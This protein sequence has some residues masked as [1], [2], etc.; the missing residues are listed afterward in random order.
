ML[1]GLRIKLGKLPWR[2][3]RALGNL[4]YSLHL[5]S[6][7]STHRIRPST[8]LTIIIALA[9][10]GFILAGGIYD[11]LER[12]ISLLPTPSGYSV[13]ISG[14]LGQQTLNESLITAF[15]Y[16]LGIGGLYMLLRSTRFA[17]RPRNAYLLLMIGTLTVLIVVYYSNALMTA[18]LTG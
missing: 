2:I 14:T 13:L 16:M 4:S 12:P 17:Y 15:L 5:T 11:I 9:I 3:K 10:V 18:K 6:G 8:T 1:E 7:P